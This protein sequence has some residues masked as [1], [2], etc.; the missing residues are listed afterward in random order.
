MG[1]HVPNNDVSDA[2]GIVFWLAAMN[3]YQ[4]AIDAMRGA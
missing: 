4:V 3:R 2:V 1:F